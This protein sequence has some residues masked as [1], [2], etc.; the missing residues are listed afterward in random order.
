R[1]TACSAPLFARALQWSYCWLVPGPEDDKNVKTILLVLKAE[2]WLP[3]L[4]LLS[5]M[6]LQLGVRM[7][8][9]W[10]P[11]FLAH[12]GSDTI[13]QHGLRVITPERVSI[14]S[15]SNHGEGA[16]NTR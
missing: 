11:R 5:G 1:W 2:I 6:P 9:C 12:L 4:G 14:G 16:L 8:A 10:M 15:P 7:R 3:A 13:L